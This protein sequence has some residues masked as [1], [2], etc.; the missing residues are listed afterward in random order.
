MPAVGKHLTAKNCVDNAIPNSVDDSSLL[1]L[2]PNENIKLYEQD[3]IILNSTLRSSKTI[4]EI[5]TKS[6]VKAYMKTLEID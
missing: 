4:I 6:Y 3:S 2:D 5:P 1:K